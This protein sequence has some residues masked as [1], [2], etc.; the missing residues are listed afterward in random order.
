VQV[1]DA[2]LGMVNDDIPESAVGK[3]FQLNEQVKAGTID[4]SFTQQRPN[5]ILLKLQRTTPYYQVRRAAARR[6]GGAAARRR[7]GGWRGPGAGGARRRPVAAS[8]AATRPPSP[9]QPHLPQ[10][11]PAGCPSWPARATP[12][13]LTALAAAAAHRPPQRNKA[14]ICSF[15]VRGECKRGAEC[16]Y[17]HEMPTT[18]ELAN[19]NIKDRYY[20]VND[21]VANKMLK[22]LGEMPKMEPPADAT[23]TT[24]YVGRPAPARRPAAL[25]P[26]HLL[27]APRHARHARHAP[28]RRPRHAPRPGPLTPRPILTPP[29][30]AAAP[31][32]RWAA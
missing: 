6:R 22:R 16:P 23:I 9:R 3:E 31:P 28:A 19:Q 10:P 11:A 13:A 32:H 20:G 15:F 24:L 17:R 4:S 5:D 30:P 18:G 26:A 29:P 1:R 21:P 2:A 12:R 8:A 27:L 25:R 7:G 14:Q